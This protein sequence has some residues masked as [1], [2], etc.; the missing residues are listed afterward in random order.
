MMKIQFTKQEVEKIL[1]DYANKMI[2]GYGFNQV[3]G[4]SYRN[5]PESVEL[6]KI[7]EDKE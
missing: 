5:L 4:G 3:I 1:L 6:V 7:E 2:E